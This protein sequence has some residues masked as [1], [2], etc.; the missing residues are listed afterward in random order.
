[1]FLSMGRF[2]RLLISGEYKSDHSLGVRIYSD[3]DELNPQAKTIA[4]NTASGNTAPYR[5]RI[6]I[7]KQKARAIKFEVY[8]TGATGTYEGLSLDGFALEYGQ[9]AGALRSKLGSSRTFGDT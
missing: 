1:M 2:W 6:H 3:Y 5:F 8:D 4:V 7:E 9:R